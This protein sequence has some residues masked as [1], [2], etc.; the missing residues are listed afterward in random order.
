VTPPPAT[1]TPPPPPPERDVEDER[2]Q[3]P[4]WLLL[5][6][7]VVAA[8]VAAA[9]L[10]RKRAAGDEDGDAPP[11]TV[12]D[13]LVPSG[14]RQGPALDLER[15]LRRTFRDGLRRLDE[16]GLVRYDPAQA[17]GRIARRLA[18]RAQ[19]EGFVVAAGVFDEVVYGRRDPTPDDVTRVE[20]GFRQVL[21]GSR[22]A[23][24]PEE[25]GA[26]AVAPRR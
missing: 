20:A 6:P 11:S 9:L 2:S 4:W 18:R 19:P 13:L 5:L 7:F 17:S 8:A 24:E 26:I 23:G 16:A 12:D 15:R 22:V 25:A 10:A 21:G 3:V 14:H 1:T